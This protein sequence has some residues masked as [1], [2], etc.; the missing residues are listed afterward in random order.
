M[1]SRLIAVL[2]AC[3]RDSKDFT[4]FVEGSQFEDTRRMVGYRIGRER[5]VVLATPDVTR[6]TLRDLTTAMEEKKFDFS[7][8][9]NEST[10]NSFTWKFVKTGGK[11][12][13]HTDYMR[14]KADHGVAPQATPLQPYLK[15]FS[16]V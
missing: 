13:L 14:K 10:H 6:F 15:E 1:S 12:P 7:E 2:D 9:P 4:L 8:I 11:K 3:L 5:R 16:L